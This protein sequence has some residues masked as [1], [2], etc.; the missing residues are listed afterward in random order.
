MSVHTQRGHKAHTHGH[1]T[2]WNI[3]LCAGL[4]PLHKDDSS[5]SARLN[6]GGTSGGNTLIDVWICNCG[7]NP[8]PEINQVGISGAILSLA[9]CAAM[10]CGRRIHFSFAAVVKPRDLAPVARSLPPR[11]ASRRTQ[12]ASLSALTA[13]A[14]WCKQSWFTRVFICSS[15]VVKVKCFYFIAPRLIRRA[16]LRVREYLTQHI[17]LCDYITLCCVPVCIYP[18]VCC[19]P[20]DS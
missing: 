6:Y 5:L 1:E 8:G 9:T 16:F 18:Y 10:F 7:S 20:P 17:C 3:F 19:S 15:V 11:W 4:K 12:P 2:C 14:T 13:N